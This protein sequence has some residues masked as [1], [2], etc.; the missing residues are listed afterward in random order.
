VPG[1]IVFRFHARDLHLVVGPAPDGK[2]V[3]FR[4]RMDGAEPGSSHGIDTDASGNGVV[5]EQRPISII[6]QPPG[7]TP[8]HV[9][10]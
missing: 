7:E 9:Y 6:R 1:S 2:P 10:D 3:R 4:V 5:H 8:A